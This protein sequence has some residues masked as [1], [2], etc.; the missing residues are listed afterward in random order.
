MNENHPSWNLPRVFNRK[1]KA[2]AGLLVGSSITV[3]Y[4]LSNHFPFFTPVQL[5]FLWIDHWIPFIPLSVW[6]YLSA[7]ALVFDAFLRSKDLS[8]SHRAFYSFLV[9]GIVSSLIFW[10]W[11]TAYPRD[12]FP[13]P[14]RMDLITESALVL[15]RQGDSILNC[16]PSLHVS[17]SY[18]ASF[19]FL[20]EQKKKFPFY[21]LWASAIALSTLSTKQHYF[22]DVITGFLLSLCIYYFFY[23]RIALKGKA[24]KFS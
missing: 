7:F 10:I 18:L 6:I 3:L 8:N 12:A 1:T 5:P 22:I 11:P 14:Q 23:L 4:L 21:F 19:I 9:L 24:A 17:G 15:L 2:T 13:L 20:G 16:S